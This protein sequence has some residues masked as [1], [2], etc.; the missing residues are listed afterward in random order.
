LG[1]AR[2]QYWCAVTGIKFNHLFDHSRS[3][4]LEAFADFKRLAGI[5]LAPVM[6]WGQESQISG[7]VVSGIDPLSV[8]IG[9]NGIPI[10]PIVEELDEIARRD[11]LRFSALCGRQKRN[12]CLNVSRVLLL[13]CHQLVPQILYEVL[14]RVGAD[15]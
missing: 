15:S 14:G 4:G 3:N 7:D 10:L 11:W 5:Q 9:V 13:V 12:L 6:L 1:S 8:G 2:S